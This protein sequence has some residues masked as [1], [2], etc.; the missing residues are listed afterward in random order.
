MTPFLGQGA[1]QAV[2]DAYCLASKLRDAAYRGLLTGPHGIER[3]LDAYASVRSGPT[4]TLQRGSRFMSELDTLFS[5]LDG[6]RNAVLWTLGA[7]G[8][9]P[10]IFLSQALPKV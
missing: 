3:A 9:W 2:Q 8:L 1:N 4:A 6:V 10:R 7:S 5:P